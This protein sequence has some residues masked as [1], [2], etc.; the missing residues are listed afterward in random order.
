L[1]IAVIAVL[2]PNFN[3]AAQIPDKFENLKVLPRDIPRDSLRA[4][5]RG[6]ASALGVQCS[7]CHSGGDPVTLVGVQFASDSKSSK[8]RAR[9]MIRMTQEINRMIATDTSGR[10][11]AIP[12]TCAT[13]HHGLPRPEPL[14]AVLAETIETSGLDSAVR[15]YK[16]LRQAMM[17]R[18]RYDFG[19]ASLNDLSQT[20]SARGKNA[21]AIKVLELNREVHPEAPTLAFLLGE[22]YLNRGDT[23]KA[24]GLYEFVLT[25]QPRN[26]GARRRLDELKKK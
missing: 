16:A 21:E 4:L 23:A 25:K 22:L 19:E 10:Q 9:S 8:V 13:C 5:M 6:Y 20:L 17:D 18:G 1:A 26:G 14:Q 7:Y 12:V 15:Q 2:A 3:I 24:V 11:F